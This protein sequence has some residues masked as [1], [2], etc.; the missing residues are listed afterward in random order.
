MAAIIFITGGAKSGKSSTAEAQIINSRFQPVAYI[1]TQGSDSK[2]DETKRSIDK[3]RS[4]RPSTWHT[5][6]QYSKLDQL[7]H[8]ETDTYQAYLIDCLTL[9]LTNYLFAFWSEDDHDETQFDLKIQSLSATEIDQLEKHVRLEL[10]RLIKSMRQ[11]NACFWVVSNEVGF[12]IVPVSPLARLFR[13]LQ[14]MLNQQ[15]AQAADKLY[16]VVSG[17]PVCIKGGAADHLK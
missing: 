17:I 9:W 15:I 7:I 3:H 1:A 6:E 8:E 16:W 11:S 12:G 13:N 10:D 5:F 4:S 14:G 2:D